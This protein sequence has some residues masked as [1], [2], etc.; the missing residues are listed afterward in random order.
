MILASGCFDGLHSGHIAYLYMAAAVEP[1]LPLV[2]AVAPDAYI[3]EA[4]YREP[5]W[6]QRQRAETVAAIRGVSRIV[7]HPEPSIAATIRALKP[8]YV[9]KGLDWLETIP[10]DVAAACVEV[11]AT[12]TFVDAE[13]TH[14][15]AVNWQ[16]I[17]EAL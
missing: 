5:R 12:L 11:G 16:A 17:G 3:R 8:A 1:S 6:T 13:R 10:Q 7:A 14:S 2:V 15:R 4:K 9:V